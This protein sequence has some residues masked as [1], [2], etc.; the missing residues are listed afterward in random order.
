MMEKGVLFRVGKGGGYKKILY[1]I[2]LCLMFSWGFTANV[3]AESACRLYRGVTFYINN[4]EGVDFD[5]EMDVR[6]L[7]LFSKGA[8]EILFKIYAPDGSLVEREVIPD[9]GVASEGF[10]VPVIGWDTEL[11]YYMTLYAAGSSPSLRW[12]AP[13]RTG[14]L[15]LLEARTFNYRVEGKGKG[16]YR[17]VLAGAP[18]HYVTARINPALKY[19]LSGHS[20]WIHGHGNMYARSYIYV[21]Q[22]TRG[23]FFAVVEPDMPRTRN[24]KLT[25]PDGKV[26]FNGP[27][28][29]GF[30]NP[31]GENWQAKTSGFTDGAYCGK[32]LT[33]E[34]SDGPG[35]YLVKAN[36]TQPREGVFADYVGMSASAVLAPDKDTAMALKG[37]TFI[38]D[39]Q[40]LWHPFQARLHDWIKA[41]PV[42]ENAPED[43]VLRL[44]QAIYD[45]FR[46][47]E[48]S[49]GR[50]SASWT[51]W[52]YAFGYYGC[53]IWRPA[54]LVL[55]SPE[56]PDELK[57][58]IREGIIMCGDRL[59][60]ATGMECVNGNAFAQINVALWY[61]HQATGDAMQKELFEIFWSRWISEGWGTGAG[62]SPSGDSQEHFAHDL[63]YG[64]YMMDNWAGG[65][66]VPVGILE[67]AP[68]GSRFHKVIERYR[69]L[70]S[71]LHCFDGNGRSVAACPWS[72]RTHQWAHADA[73]SWLDKGG[74]KWKGEPGPDFTVNVNDGGEWFA[75]R[76]KNYYML[77]FHGRLAPQWMSEC[78]QGQL[79]FGGGVICQLVVPGKGVVL[80]STLPD[81][82]GKGTHPDNWR[83]FHVHGVVG[84]LWD[85][86][87]LVA[88][89]SEHFD[90][91]L[92]GTV[93]TSSGEVRDTHVR[94]FRRYN[95]APDGVDCEVALSESDY[96][97][98]LSLWNSSR[99]WSDVKEA[100]EMI[101]YWTS[102]DEEAAVS[103]R[104]D[105]GKFEPLSDKLVET[106]VVRIERGGYGVDIKLAEPRGVVLGANKTVM[107]SIVPRGEK[108]VPA[109]DVTLKYRLVPFQ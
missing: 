55:K 73:R 56:A 9:D 89:I 79:G 49:D 70:Y 42:P 17:V 93:L 35:D 103:V 20:T 4:P 46:L 78:F 105:S 75:A 10:P 25:G 15:D 6:D 83:N 8:R 1:V 5:F 22:G 41:N 107:I 18:D 29:G 14:Q 81:S 39:G 23:L 11:Q 48:T 38:H 12:S 51:N 67:D 65:T 72:S 34:I 97:P 109:A 43:S 58:I 82:Y 98:I 54:W 86:R 16:V 57:S 44:V 100:W 2:V 92:N 13:G 80:A 106:D 36:L 59:A 27:A 19:G 32:L 104:L 24:F 68:A 77:T 37:G 69:D 45:G 76:R 3:N 64:S 62:L 66:W 96:G 84:E 26:I 60:F 33:L 71:Y 94:S 85:G 28:T 31:S 7:N 30:V 88:G 91:K 102:K 87:P 101:P 21:P 61:A 108:V 63:H 74:R 50:G 53:K 95:F 47:I 52:A 99:T 40:V 90:A